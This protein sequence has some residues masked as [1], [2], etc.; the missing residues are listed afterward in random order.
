MSK[1]SKFIVKSLD[2]TTWM[3]FSISVYH[4]LK[5]PDYGAVT[6]WPVRDPEGYS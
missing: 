1:N 6:F 3:P 2:S 5:V 4:I